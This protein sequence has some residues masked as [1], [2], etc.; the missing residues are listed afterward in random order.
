MLGQLI[1]DFKDAF[2]EQ[3]EL[4]TKAAKDTDLKF[5]QLEVYLKKWQNPAEGRRF[6]LSCSCAHRHLLWL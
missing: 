2:K 4:Y 3:P 6:S 1:L 5:E